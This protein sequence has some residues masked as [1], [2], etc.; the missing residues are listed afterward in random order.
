MAPG[1]WLGRLRKLLA[2][3]LVTWKTWP[4]RRFS[5]KPKKNT[6]LVT[7]AE[8]QNRILA[9]RRAVRKNADKT[10]ADHPEDSPVEREMFIA[11]IMAGARVAMMAMI[12]ALGFET[13]WL[14]NDDEGW[15]WEPPRDNGRGVPGPE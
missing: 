4:T 3:S 15:S 8:L 12:E 9:I 6:A 13:E 10:W 2:W 1:S 14:V 11:G 5:V 7:E